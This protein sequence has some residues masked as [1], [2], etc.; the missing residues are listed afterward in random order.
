MSDR[1]SAS[2]NW[3]L[4]VAVLGVVIAL[5]A[6]IWYQQRRFERL[7][8]T[9][10][11]L[12][13]EPPPVAAPAAAAL[14]VPLPP[15]TGAPSN[16]PQIDAPH[17]DPRKDD[18]RRLLESAS[19]T[20]YQFSA[21][22]KINDDWGKAIETARKDGE[23]SLPRP[24]ADLARERA[25]ALDKLLSPDQRKRYDAFESAAGAPRTRFVAADGRTFEHVAFE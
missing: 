11:S 14:A 24:I 8:Q 13:R 3:P 1:A 16:M 23:K 18:S 4:V 17:V 15:G 10:E 25:E 6:F 19:L 7:E 22:R 2:N 21:L 12:R 5:G 20:P 9:L